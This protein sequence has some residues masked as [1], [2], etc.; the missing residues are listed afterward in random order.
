[1]FTR[2]MGL[3]PSCI[4]SLSLWHPSK[5][6]GSVLSE[7]ASKSTLQHLSFQA[8]SSN[9]RVISFLYPTVWVTLS[10]GTAPPSQLLIPQRGRV[11]VCS[12]SNESSSLCHRARMPHHPLLNRREAQG[13][14][15][16]GVWGKS[17]KPDIFKLCSTDPLEMLHLGAGPGT[18]WQ[19]GLGFLYRKYIH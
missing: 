17:V 19:E 8:S 14:K 6:P 9:L 16:G 12:Q 18:S 5:A 4:I 3:L 11:Y 10:L 15:V 7:M 1:M 13:W 2:E